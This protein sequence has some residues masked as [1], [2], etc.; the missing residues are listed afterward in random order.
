MRMKLH[1]TGALNPGLFLSFFKILFFQ[2]TEAPE[3][4]FF[5]KMWTF[6]E[7]FEKQQKQS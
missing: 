7:L 5:K 4:H 2:N 3:I 1:K 6:F